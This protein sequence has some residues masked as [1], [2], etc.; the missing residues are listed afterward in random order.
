VVGWADLL[1]GKKNVQWEKRNRSGKMRD[2]KSHAPEQ[3]QV[4]PHA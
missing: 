4:A 2:K 1:P 3:L